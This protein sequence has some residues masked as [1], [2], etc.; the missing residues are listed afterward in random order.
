MNITEHGLGSNL[1]RSCWMFSRIQRRRLHRTSDCKLA[2]VARSVT[3]WMG[4][5]SVG[6][7]C[8]VSMTIKVQFTLASIILSFHWFHQF[9]WHFDLTLFCSDNSNSRT[10]PSTYYIILIVKT[11]L[12]Y[13][14]M[15][16]RA[17]R[18]KICCGLKSMTFLGS[19][20]R[21]SL[22]VLGI[23]VVR[24]GFIPLFLFCNISPNNRNLT[25]VSCFL[26]LYFRLLLNLTFTMDASSIEN[27]F[28]KTWNDR[29]A[30][31]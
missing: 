31:K 20:T 19:T 14:R 5:G 17:V 24:L 2:P 15:S 30:L 22:I 27:I 11:L 28:T 26:S 8:P 21:G 16:Y 25:S 7:Y 9:F 12:K 3:V 1:L 18:S 13:T 29:L 10:R 23:A 6:S 4:R